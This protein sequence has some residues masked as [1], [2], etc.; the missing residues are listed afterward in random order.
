MKVVIERE[1]G[2]T[3]TM[4]DHMLATPRQ[5]GDTLGTHTESAE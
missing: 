3:Q 2:E 1:M 4:R 5:L